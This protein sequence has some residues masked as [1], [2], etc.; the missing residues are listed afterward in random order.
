MSAVE[1]LEGS[2]TCPQARPVG[3]YGELAAAADCKVLRGVIGHAPAGADEAALY[4][5]LVQWLPPVPTPCSYTLYM[6]GVAVIA[7]REGRSLKL[8]KDPP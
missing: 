6:L 5:T 2:I 4:L 8:S 3:Q 7:G 1:Q